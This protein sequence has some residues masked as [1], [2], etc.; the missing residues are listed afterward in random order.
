MKNR[1]QTKIVWFQ[2]Q[3]KTLSNKLDKIL[4]TKQRQAHST[5][6]SQLKNTCSLF[7]EFLGK[8]YNQEQHKTL[9]TIEERHEPKQTK[10]KPG[11]PRSGTLYII[12]VSE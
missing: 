7:K 8:N 5:L 6:Y 2:W 4:T 3:T 1:Y 9:S 12:T 11:K 10:V